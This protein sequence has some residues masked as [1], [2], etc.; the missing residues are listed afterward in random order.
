MRL[1]MEQRM[2]GQMT[3]AF[4]R[5]RLYAGLCAGL[6]HRLERRSQRGG[7]RGGGSFSLVPGAT[8]R[9]PA[10]PRAGRGC[11]QTALAPAVRASP[12][13]PARLAMVPKAVFPRA[14]HLSRAVAASGRT[15]PWQGQ[16][17]R[18]RRLYQ[19]IR[20][21][22]PLVSPGTQPRGAR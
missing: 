5:R 14:L 11:A 7:G 18:H 9:A 3:R 21:R 19:T 12:A 8:A 10:L 13:A 16:G 1:W 15:G 4:I 17:D 2:N 22:G 20:S 6:R